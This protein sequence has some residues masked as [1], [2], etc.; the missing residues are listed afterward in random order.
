MF[1]KALDADRDQLAKLKKQLKALHSA[2]SGT[3]F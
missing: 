3:I 2:G 1:L